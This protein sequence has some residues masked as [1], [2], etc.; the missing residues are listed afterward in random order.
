M[1]DFKDIV[2]FSLKITQNFPGQSRELSVK[3]PG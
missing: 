3:P 2:V 1:K